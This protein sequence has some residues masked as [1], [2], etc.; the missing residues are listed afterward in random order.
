MTAIDETTKDFEIDRASDTTCDNCCKEC[1]LFWARMDH[2]STCYPID[3]DQFRYEE[4][5]A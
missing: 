5:T 3:Y 2:Q 1:H 4:V